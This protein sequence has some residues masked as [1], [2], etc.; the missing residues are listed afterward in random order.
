MRNRILTICL[1]V[2]L[3]LSSNQAFGATAKA[4]GTCLKNGLKSG[5]LIC[6]KVNGKLKWQIVKKAQTI[7][8]SVAQQGSI[9]DKSIDFTFSS[10]SNLTVTA[11]ALTPDVCGLGKSLILISGTPG[12]CRFSLTQI[13]NAYFAPAKSVLVEV[14]IFGTNVIQ[15]QLPGALLLSQG[16]YQVSATSSSNLTVTLTS[17][18]TTVCTIANSSLTLLQAGTCTVM[19][20][21]VGGDLI[22]PA[23]P[24]TQMV[25]ISTSRVTADLPDTISGFQIKPVYV[26]PFDGTDNSYDTNGFIAAILDEGNSYL[27]SQIGLTL[28]IDRTSTGYDIQFMKS[29]ITTAE[30]MHS[31]NLLGQLL[32]EL[33]AMEDPGVN[34][35]NYTFFVDVPILDDGAACGYARQPGMFSLVAIGSSCSGPSLTF[36]NYASS[37]WVH[38]NFHNFGVGHFNDSCD[39]MRGA[40]TCKS[41]QSPTIDKERTRYVGASALGVGDTVLS[42]DILKLRVWVGY[43]SRTDLLADCILDPGTRSDGLHFAYCSTGTRAIG[44]LTSCWNPIN[45]VELQEQINGSWVSLGTGNNWFQ[46][47]GTRISW[48]CGTG[49]SAPWK[50]LTVNTP[51]LSHYKWI[52]NGQVSE[53]LNVIWV[54]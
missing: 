43:T 36:R 38:E 3:S 15:F 40:Q 9:S 4:D 37:T 16:I 30:F 10:S 52:V 42:Q 22:P 8:F 32:N 2:A 12:L 47:W 7:T 31:P 23:D 54:N 11:T 19:A 48:T 46:P 14:T 24:V 34:R 27:N 28:P 20:T 18:T 35:K 6:D 25:Q 26:V 53:E 41:D 45:S 29:K 39:L 13:G 44:A 33:K 17:S 21:Q 5:S 49:F 1:L 50:E 51:G